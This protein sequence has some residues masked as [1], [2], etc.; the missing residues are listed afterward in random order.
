MDSDFGALAL[1]VITLLAVLS[2]PQLIWTRR[3]VERV[4]GWLANSRQGVE[5][6]P[7]A[8]F[9]QKAQWGWLAGI[10]V[11]LVLIVDAQFDSA[12][13]GRPETISLCAA[14][15]FCCLIQ[16]I[17][18]TKSEAMCRQVSRFMAQASENVVTEESLQRQL[19]SLGRLTLVWLVFV[20]AHAVI[21]GLIL[22]A[23]GLDEIAS[24]AGQLLLMFVL[25][26]VPGLI[27]L[28]VMR[29]VV[30]ARA[31]QAQFLWFLAITIRSRRPLASELIGW[32]RA[33]PGRFGSRVMEV[34]RDIGA[35][36]SLADA[37]QA[38]PGLLASSDLMSLRVAEHTGTQAETLRDC[39]TRQ[40]QSLKGDAVIRNASGTAIW[41]WAVVM[42]AVTLTTFLMYYIVPKFKQ[43]FLGFGTELPGV[44]VLLI[45]ISDAFVR[46]GILFSPLMAAL[47]MILLWS[48]GEAFL[49]GWSETWLAWRLGFGRQS[50]I[51]RLLRRL[52]GAVVSNHPWP[53][54]L[55]PMI[56]KHPQR[57]IRS[58]LE[59]VLGRVTAGMGVWPAMCDS[60]L[61]TARDVSLLVM[62]E[63]ANN[64]AWAL[65]ALAESKERTLAHRW[66]VWLTVAVPIC[67]IAAGL[68]VLLICVGFFM[69]LVK[70]LNDLS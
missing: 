45:S 59:R 31:Q 9:S 18:S 10:V 40:T 4:Q 27:A 60:G 48:C 12:A 49:H 32:G 13:V 34:A 30:E 26:V 68:M 54:A 39:A 16:W 38:Q 24:A 21:A 64:L 63:R 14:V 20:T 15:S 25:I 5:L 51:P 44:T 41:L 65:S 57:D 33:H 52:R 67:T 7:F 28:M 47:S 37:L 3:I 29:W 1:G 19:T 50:E 46:Y 62:A 11:S 17:I 61:L 69:P 22:I 55:R 43:I 70:L 35:G 8:S 36:E 6:V 42:V 2:L 66:Q 23:V 58:R 56:L 53:T